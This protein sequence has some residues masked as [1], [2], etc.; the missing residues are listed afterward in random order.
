MLAREQHL[1]KKIQMIF[2]LL[3][4]AAISLAM[5]YLVDRHG[6][7]LLSFLRK[8]DPTTKVPPLHF[9]ALGWDFTLTM[10]LT[11]IYLL[12]LGYYDL[13]SFASFVKRT[14]ISIQA[15]LLSLGTCAL[16]SF[17]L[18]LRAMDR[19]VILLSLAVFLPIHSLKNYYLRHLDKQRAKHGITSKCLLITS[20]TAYKQDIELLQEQQFKAV[21]FSAVYFVT[22]ADEAL[23]NSITCP[24]A[25]NLDEAR[26]LIKNHSLEL[27]ILR[28]ASVGSEQTETILKASDEL[29]LDVW[30]FSDMLLGQ[31]RKFEMDHYMSLPIII[32]HAVE[33]RPTQVYC[34]RGLDILVSSL[35]L[36]LLSPVLLF[37]AAWVRFDSKGSSLFIQER[38]GLR[39]KRFK[40]LK[41]RTMVAKA[42]E[43]QSDLLDLN[44]M[45]GPAFKITADPRVTRLGKILRKYSLDE[46]PQLLNVLSGEMSLVGPRPLPVHETL[47]FPEWKDR[48]RLSVKPGMT[49]LWQVSGRSDCSDFSEL[50]LLDLKYI[51]TWNLLLDFEI[52]LKTIPVVFTGRGAK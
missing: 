26:A 38:S 29:G 40:M 42:E 21:R 31:G 8:A 16:F 14:M 25:S 46:L 32:Y 15:V 24:I 6:N 30:F 5:F 13:D 36:L 37:I 23:R 12:L 3:I 10:A 35:A 39:G 17:F 18:P 51:D 28:F 50:I 52:L 20:P 48:R 44:E 47:A 33:H 41:F 45:S 7:E 27:I 9:H 49:G 19:L 34:K 2:D 43:M 22:P 1:R 11:A 4:I